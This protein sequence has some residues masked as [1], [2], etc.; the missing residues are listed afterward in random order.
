MLSAEAIYGENSWESE[1]N[2][3]DRKVKEKNIEIYNRV[4]DNKAMATASTRNATTNTM[5]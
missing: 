1:E 4:C 3:R 2:V 5:K